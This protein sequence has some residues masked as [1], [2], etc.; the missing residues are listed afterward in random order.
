M[1]KNR[2][3]ERLPIHPKYWPI[4]LGLALLRLL[5]TL[6][7]RVQLM[8][9]KQLGNLLFHVA[10]TRRRVAATNIKL[11]FPELSDA[12]RASILR[13]H[14]HSMG[15][16]LFELGLSWWG[17]DKRLAAL[18]E[19]EGLEYLESAIAGGN[20][21][22]LLG[23]H[24]TTLDI[25][26]HLLATQT[27]LSIRSMY[28]PHENPVIEYVMRNGRESYLESLIPR[29]DI[30]GL[31]RSL[32]QNKAVWYAP[33]QH[34]E[35]K[36]SALVPF[37]G[38]PT[39]TNTGTS[40]IAKMSKTA[41]IPFVSVRKED[42]SGYALKLLPPLDNFPTDDEVADAARIHQLFETQIRN[43]KAQYFWVHKRFKRKRIAGEDPYQKSP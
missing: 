34:Y 29:D 16:M 6:P 41:V 37:F 19:I 13:K 35:G 11:C 32:K 17:G 10:K 21:A 9:G 12:A 25:S 36:G 1:Q 31:I 42:G 5:N 38:I 43:N 3:S 20:G 40:R 18:T 7:F 2:P 28:R 24:Y 23:A 27:D 39:P 33:D 14:F 26:G 4:W 15:I 8:L 30:R 22:L